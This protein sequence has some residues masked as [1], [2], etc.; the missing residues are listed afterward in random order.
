MLTALW[1]WLVLFEY[2]F[3]L[4]T[5]V[6]VST[7]MCQSSIVHRFLRLERVKQSFQK[8]SLWSVFVTFVGHRTE[9]VPDK[10]GR[11][12]PEVTEQNREQS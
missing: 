2:C 8:W 4:S 6:T 12:S 11:I 9:K 5:Q 3:L 1:I 7:D 10:T